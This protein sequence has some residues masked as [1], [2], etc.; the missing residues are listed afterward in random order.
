MPGPEPSQRLLDRVAKAQCLECGYRL[1]NLP[2]NRCPECGRW[3]DPADPRT[4]NIPGW[5]PPKE[6][7]KPWPESA[8]GN[9][10]GGAVLATF[11]FLPWPFPQ[12]PV[13]FGALAWCV[14]GY[15]WIRRR[16]GLLKHMREGIAWRGWVKLLLVVS[17][18]L[19]WVPEVDRCPHATVYKF[20]L[21]G[22][23]WSDNNGPCGENRVEGGGHIRGRWYWATSR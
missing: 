15:Y 1:C 13:L 11:G 19:F 9:M 8:G 23:A 18:V 7:R 10:L 3:F 4:M 6:K 20:H 16:L 17:F 14:V 5:R 22:I 12:A 2:T 21:F